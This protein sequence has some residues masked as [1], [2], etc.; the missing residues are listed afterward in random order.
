LSDKDLKAAL[1][2][3]GVPAKAADAIIAENENARI[4]GLRSSLPLLPSSR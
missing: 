1:D 3:H 2:A 4:D